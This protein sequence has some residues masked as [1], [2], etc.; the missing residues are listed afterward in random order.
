M[1]RKKAGGIAE[2]VRTIAYAALIA[3]VVRTFLFE[4]FN[5]P[6]GSMLPT[7]L[8]GDY[9]FVSKYSYGYSRHSFPFSPNLF[10][11]R[12]LGGQ[13][14]RGDVAVFKLPSDN[15]TDYIKRVIGLPG[16]RIM[17]R[18][19]TLH[20]NGVA[21]TRQKIEGE[22]PEAPGG[23]I[24]LETLP[25]GISHRIREAGDN[26]F[27]DHTREY[28][29]P[30]GHFF[31]MGDN[32][33][34]SQDSRFIGPIPAENLVGRAEILFFSVDGSAALWEVWRWPMA[35]RWSRLLKMVE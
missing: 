29:V 30:P 33:D 21:V 9:L 28:V 31:V 14:E 20:I 19:G 10:S 1:A 12:V 5:I 25:N 11:G 13:P 18:D 27:G 22:D 34:N 23:T 2:T 7:L 32:R 3:L 16:D 15:S 24:Y 17:V 35:I 4:P 6:S 26:E 8:I